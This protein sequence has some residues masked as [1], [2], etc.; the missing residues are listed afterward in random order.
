MVWCKRCTAFSNAFSKILASFRSMI[1]L[2]LP[3]YF[4]FAGRQHSSSSATSGSN[5]FETSCTVGSLYQKRRLLEWELAQYHGNLL[6]WHELFGQIKRTSDCAA[7]T[8]DVKLNYLKTLVTEKAKTTFATFF[9]CTM[10]YKE[11]LKSGELKIAQ[12]QAVVSTFQ[13]IWTTST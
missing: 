8:H 10:K 12:N 6:D 1:V 5:V 3:E 11:L 13:T 4:P 7:L 9:Y 2:E